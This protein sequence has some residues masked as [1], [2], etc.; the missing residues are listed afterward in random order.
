MF[1]NEKKFTGLLP[2]VYLIYEYSFV[3]DT[4]DVLMRKT[5]KPISNISVTSKVPYLR[6][7]DKCLTEIS[8]MFCISCTR[9]LV[10]IYSSILDIRTSSKKE[11]DDSVAE[12][13]TGS[14]IADSV[15]TIFK[16]IFC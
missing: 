12:E 15:S 10:D 11:F 9:Y 3:T 7:R 5:D 13:D 2:I 16:T 1:R 8:I 6:V 4:L 14:V